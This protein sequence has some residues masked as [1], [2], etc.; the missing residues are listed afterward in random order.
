MTT[1]LATITTSFFGESKQLEA[2][3]I[4]TLLNDD[5]TDTIKIAVG[6]ATPDG[7]DGE[8]KYI[9][10]PGSAVDIGPGETILRFAAVANAPKL[11]ISSIVAE[12][13]VLAACRVS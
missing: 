9:L 7:A 10:S 13:S 1:K 6:T 12:A 4:Y 3:R 2:N 8:D 11:L 5:A